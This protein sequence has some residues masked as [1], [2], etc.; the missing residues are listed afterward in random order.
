[1]EKPNRMVY[2]INID[3][4]D[5]RIVEK[6]LNHRIMNMDKMQDLLGIHFSILDTSVCGDSIKGVEDELVDLLSEFIHSMN[7][8]HQYC[9][10][11]SRNDV[12]MSISENMYINV[13]QIYDDVYGTFLNKIVSDLEEF[14]QKNKLKAVKSVFIDSLR[15][16]DIEKCFVESCL[17]VKEDLYRLRTA[18]KIMDDMIE[19]AKVFMD[20]PSLGITSDGP[21]D[22]L[23]YFTDMTFVLYNSDFPKDLVECI[24]KT[25][26]YF[27]KEYSCTILD[28]RAISIN[29][30]ST[31]T[32]TPIT[33][34]KIDDSLSNSG[35]K[36]IK[37]RK[38]EDK[39]IYE[40]HFTTR[41]LV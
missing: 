9:I 15:V 1:M 6:V 8:L 2:G 25:F 34:E 35:E 24:E 28:S 14:V 23:N 40:P 26:P 39:S 29:S 36:K 20:I 30:S 7:V 17:K 13:S 5:D 32:E 21:K 31:S 33:V 27:L 3:G 10:I 4:N 12:E 41:S 22:F 11:E 38:E 16:V 19:M 37:R 18:M